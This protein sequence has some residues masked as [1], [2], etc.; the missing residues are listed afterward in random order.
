[1]EKKII[2]LTGF[3]GSGKSTIGPIL[4]NTIGWN[5]MDLDKKIETIEHQRI[6]EIFK[7]KGQNYFR[8]V[9]NKLLIE[10]STLENT[11]ISLGGGTIIYQDNIQLLKNSGYIIYLKTSPEIIYLRLRNKVDRP[12]FQ[13][14]EQ[15]PMSKSEA[16]NKI[17]KILK[18]REPYYDQA[19][20]TFNVENLSIGRS[21]D[22]L[23][24]LIQKKF[25]IY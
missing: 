1:M 11:I 3:M 4:A 14:A 12:T 13:T 10:N 24:K 20:I 23:A 2:Y 19:D 9:E 7:T 6:T 5:F 8:T 18:Q 25:K 15:F 16:M 17:N 22:S 21:V